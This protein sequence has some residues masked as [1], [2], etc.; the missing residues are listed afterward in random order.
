MF[1]PYLPAISLAGLALLLVLC[2]PLARVQKLVL[3]L[4]ALV[5]RLALLAFLGASAYLWFRPGQLPAEVMDTSNAFLSTF[6]GL[7]GVLPGPGTPYFGICAA[8]FLV[9]MLLPLL[10]VLDVSRKLAGWRLRR[11]RALAAA[12]EAVE[13]PAPAPAVQ[14]VN[15]RAA[16]D[17]LAGVV[18][19]KPLSAT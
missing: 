18:A 10:A 6:P 2:L 16:A 14:R 17:A 1:E 8:A 5:L 12:P 19:R 3:E 4:S 13:S 9:S 11:L 7:R 15:R